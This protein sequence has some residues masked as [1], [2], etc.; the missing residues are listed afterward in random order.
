MENKFE[1][2]VVILVII[3]M[4]ALFVIFAY[5]KH[6][7]KITHENNKGEIV[8]LRQEIKQLES[9]KKLLEKQV[10]LYK[11]LLKEKENG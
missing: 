9:E 2:A 7:D 6:Q 3:L 4:F 5:F 11:E 1:A 10:E 8:K